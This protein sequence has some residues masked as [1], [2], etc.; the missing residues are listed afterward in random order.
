[1]GELTLVPGGNQYYVTHQDVRMGRMWE[2]A[3]MRLQIDLSRKGRPF[4]NI[5][6]DHPVPENLRPYLPRV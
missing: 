1:M 5:T 3:E 6:G 4:R 2:E